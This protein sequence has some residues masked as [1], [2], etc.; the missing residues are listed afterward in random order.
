[1]IGTFQ[2]V[3]EG[4]LDPFKIVWCEDYQ[5]GLLGMRRRVGIVPAGR[6]KSSSR[7]QLSHQHY[8]QGNFMDAPLNL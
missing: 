6:I 2:V 3:G 8:H 1:M 7:R 5:E 4:V